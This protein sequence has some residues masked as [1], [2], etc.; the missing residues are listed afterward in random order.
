MG[1]EKQ[2]SGNGDTRDKVMRQEGQM[3]SVKV[4]IGNIR[5]KT[6]KNAEDIVECQ[7]EIKGLKKG[8][9]EIK[10]M[11]RPMSEH[12]QNGKKGR[13]MHLVKIFFIVIVAMIIFLFG[14]V[15]AARLGGVNVIE[16]L[17]G[18]TEFTSAVKGDD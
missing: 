14:L 16:L 11:I 15:G 4:D 12:A 18:L 9:K 2:T 6:D 3:D 5:E 7:T 1:K 17:R 8:Q 10:D 13:L